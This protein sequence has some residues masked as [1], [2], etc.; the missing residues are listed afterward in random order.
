MVE[1]Q[2]LAIKAIFDQNISSISP[3]IPFNFHFDL[4]LIEWGI[5]K[6]TN[7]IRR[8]LQQ[9]DKEACSGVIWRGKLWFFIFS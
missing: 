5:N 9:G 7:P 3:K 8:K 2:V 4:A 6:T 1:C